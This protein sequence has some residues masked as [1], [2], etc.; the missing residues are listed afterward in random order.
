MEDDSERFDHLL[1]G[2]ST[3]KLF[4]THDT[5]FQTYHPVNSGY[6]SIEQSSKKLVFRVIFPKILIFF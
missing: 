6:L 3:K 1:P 5:L 4:Q 2:Q